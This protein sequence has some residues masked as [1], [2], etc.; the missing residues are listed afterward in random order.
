MAI[1]AAGSL[2]AAGV[3]V[4]AGCTEYVKPLPA[5]VQPAVTIASLKDRDPATTVLSSLTFDIPVGATLGQLS[6][7]AGGYCTNRQPITY[8]RGNQ[9]SD[10]SLYH[11][12]F[13]EVMGQAG[14]PVEQVQ[15]FEGEEVKKAD[16]QI[17]ATIKEMVLNICYPELY[18]DKGHAIGETYVKIEWALFSPIERKVVFTWESEG[19]SPEQFDT[20]LGETGIVREAFRE[21]LTGLVSQAGFADTVA[22]KKGSAPSVAKVA[23]SILLQQP[24]ARAIR[25]DGSIDLIRKAIVTIRSNNGEG[26]G[27]AVGDGSYVVTAAHVV[28]GDTRVRLIQ[29]TG[30]ARYGDV[31]RVDRGRDLALIK[32]S[33]GKLQPL[34]LSE[35]PIR[36]GFEVYAAGSPMG[37]QFA[38]SVT[39]GV[40][41]GF[42]HIDE[43]DYIQSDVKV[44]PGSSGGP[45]L[46]VNG[47]VIGVSCMGVTISG[48]PA[49]M[50][51]FIPV[52][53]VFKSL[54]LSVK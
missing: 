32:L 12:V 10:T 35:T 39:K 7:G 52:R 45:L 47:N 36:E 5:A 44:L 17:A 21:A 25:M 2:I 50:N 34:H 20:R 33:E 23:N 30:E 14:V 46:D 49:G 24:A 18:I 31:V 37:E 13:K 48:V 3:L 1:K 15:R 27:F 9:K 26:S 8:N 51:F 16:L 54:S 22:R 19:R 41:S 11:S 28:S 42:R 43:R 6:A 53:D 40:V 38:F 29:A 4:L